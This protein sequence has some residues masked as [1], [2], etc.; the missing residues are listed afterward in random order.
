MRRFLLVVGVLLRRARRSAAQVSG[1]C[2]RAG[3][4]R[5]SLLAD[6]RYV[7]AQAAYRRALGT[8]D[9]ALLGS[10]RSRAGARAAADGRFSGRLRRL[11]RAW[12]AATPR[13][14]R[15]RRCAAMPSGRSA[16][17]RRPSRRTRPRWRPIRVSARARHGRARSLAA[18]NRLADAL[19]RCGSRAPAEFAR[20]G[21]PPHARRRSTSACAISTTRPDRSPPTSISCPTRTAARRPRGPAPRSGSSSPSKGA[22]RSRSTRRRRSGVWTMPIRIRGDK[23]TVAGKVNGGSQ[24]F[25]LDTG[26]ER[27]V[28]SLDVARRRGVVRHH[29]H[30][31]R[32]R[33]RRRHC[34]A[35]RSGGSTR[36]RSAA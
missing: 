7:D 12:P 31:D 1:R 32:G 24:E 14:R 20:G 36:S 13:T 33:R 23:V 8:D 22:C 26:A 30:A 17:S 11:I 10:G 34:A 21:V 4:A 3:A 27:T 9:E 35:S 6:G 19:S 15:S 2:R 18:R 25:L 28:I 5:R 16:D 29:L